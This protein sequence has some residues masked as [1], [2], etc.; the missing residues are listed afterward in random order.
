MQML[1]IEKAVMV[2]S[3]Y[4]KEEEKKNSGVAIL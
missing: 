3:D 1:A 4:E 2:S